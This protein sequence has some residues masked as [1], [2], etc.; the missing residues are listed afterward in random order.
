MALSPELRARAQR[1]E[2]EWELPPLS[3]IDFLEEIADEGWLTDQNPRAAE[4]VGDP[5]LLS[6]MA[7][8]WP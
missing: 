5:A 4:V 7:P 1:Y 6:P 3:V 2:Q 8:M